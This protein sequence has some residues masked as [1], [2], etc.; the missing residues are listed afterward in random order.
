MADLYTVRDIASKLNTT[1]P[2]VERMLSEKGIQPYERK[3][4]LRFYDKD[5]VD[6][7]E[8]EVE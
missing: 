7:L 1:F 5:A 6:L 3:G 2:E 4:L 8:E